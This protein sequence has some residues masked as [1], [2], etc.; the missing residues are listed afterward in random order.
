[1]K[2]TALL[3]RIKALLRDYA[4]LSRDYGLLLAPV[5]CMCAE[6]YNKQ[7]AANWVSFDLNVSCLA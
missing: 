2:V 7:K 5:R 4:S 3:N 6:L 1:M